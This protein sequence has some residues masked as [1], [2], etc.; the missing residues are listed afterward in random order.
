LSLPLPVLRLKSDPSAMCNRQGC[1]AR[2]QSSGHQENA[3]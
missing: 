3:P 1:A 2:M